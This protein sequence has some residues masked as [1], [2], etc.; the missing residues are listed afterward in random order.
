MI[1]LPTSMPPAQEI[2]TLDD[3]RRIVKTQPFILVGTNGVYA[4]DY[5][6]Y[7]MAP[8][9]ATQISEQSTGE[10]I[11]VRITMPAPRLIALKPAG[12]P[13]IAIGGA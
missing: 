11:N 7:E 12:K 13:E 1:S 10:G 5:A 6:V 4:L 8:E 2:S 3:G 9:S